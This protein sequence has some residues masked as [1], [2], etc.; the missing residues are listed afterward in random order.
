VPEGGDVVNGQVVGHAEPTDDDPA[1]PEKDHAESRDTP[2][3]DTT[4]VIVFQLS[5][6]DYPFL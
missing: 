2:Y 3:N 1:R 6:P 5:T 4:L